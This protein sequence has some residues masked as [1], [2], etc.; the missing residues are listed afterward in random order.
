MKFES[1]C[2][3]KMCGWKAKRILRKKALDLNCPYCGA[4]KALEPIL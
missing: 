2:R 3:C 4:F 1:G